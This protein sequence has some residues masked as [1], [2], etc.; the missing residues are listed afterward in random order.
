MRIV[1]YLFLG[2]AALVLS[3]LAA[4]F[5]YPFEPLIQKRLQSIAYDAGY[6]LV[7]EGDTQ[8]KRSLNPLYAMRDVRI[9]HRGAADR[10]PT[11]VAKG[12]RGR[13][14][15]IAL[16]RGRIVLSDIVF[17][18]P[19]F[20]VERASG[21]R[22]SWSGIAELQSFANQDRD[23]AVQLS[24]VSIINGA[25]QIGDDA[26]DN[27]YRV[28]SI[29]LD[30]SAGAL[31]APLEAAGHISYLGKTLELTAKIASLEAFFQDK[32][33]GFT[34]TVSTG[35]G[36]LALAGDISASQAPFY[37]GR[38]TLQVSNF[39]DAV[40]MFSLNAAGFENGP[41]RLL[42]EGQSELTQNNLKISPVQLTLDAHKAQ[43]TIEIAFAENSVPE[44]RADLSSPLL[45]LTAYFP[46]AQPLRRSESNPLPPASV[47]ATEIS[48]ASA[49]ELL[50]AY[51]SK[52]EEGAQA[53]TRRSV[54]KSQ[55]NWPNN[56]LPWTTLDGLKMSSNFKAQR[57]LVQDKVIEDAEFTISVDG[58]ALTLVVEQAKVFGG[59]ITAAGTVDTS[60]PEIVCTAKLSI[61]KVALAGLI[62]QSGLRTVGSALE[63]A[64][65]SGQANFQAPRC[66]TL[67][68]LVASLKGDAKIALFDGTFVIRNQW[69]KWI[70][71]FGLPTTVPFEELGG[72]FSVT[73]G[74]AV[75]QDLGMSGAPLTVNGNGTIRIPDR[76]LEF[77]ARVR[78][79]RRANA[80]GGSAR[81][82]LSFSPTL[83]IRGPWDNLNFDFSTFETLFRSPGPLQAA[84]DQWG[85]DGTLDDEFKDL[86]RR[87][88]D[89][90]PNV[91]EEVRAQVQ[92]IEER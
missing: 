34:G 82:F 47:K 4:L 84:L 3:A 88:V 89:I 37:K 59:V 91:P 17:D 65:G 79:V 49:K 46:F 92:S 78:R 20:F 42:I 66:T 73:E 40:S 72:S 75:N 18:S 52:R 44:V 23:L 6:N 43:G 2:V 63:N 24:S 11:L 39:K 56:P 8:L 9:A 50:K 16:L 36:A 69:V 77:T 13:L 33:V 61:S 10:K 87:A 35:F 53:E 74:I 22:R 19:Q 48:P 83:S 27:R 29:N 14:N 15:L 64:K 76:W 58:K 51:I 86:L 25:L 1:V 68:S 7:V 54:P 85:A 67:R 26:D 5:I 90:T 70:E 38:S 62:P 30:V 71:W 28:E 45:D 12:V 81:R 55:E 21:D 80:D 31:N 41:E 32:R 57:I 60:V